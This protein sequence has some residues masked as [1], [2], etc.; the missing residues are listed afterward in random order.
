MVKRKKAIVLLEN[1][2]SLEGYSF[3]AE[4]EVCA[5][6]VFNTAM[7]GYQEIISD[8]SYTGQAVVMTYPLIGNYGVNSFDDESDGMKAEALIVKELSSVA[9]NWM[10]EGTLADYLKK[11]NRIG[12]EGV[13]TRALTRVLRTK[14][15]MKGI[16]STKD[17]D[18]KSLKK[19]LSSAP[20]IGDAD[21][22]SK[23]S[24]KKVYDWKDAEDDNP[25]H[26]SKHSVAVIDCGVKRSI[27]RNMKNYFGK[28][29]VFPASTS[30]DEV[31][32]YN[33]DGI[34]LSNGPGDPEAVTGVVA[35][36][37][38][39]IERL[40]KGETKVPLLGICLGHQMLGLALGGKTYKLTFG[41]H[42]GNHPVKDL[43][44]GRIDITS[45][46]HNY[47]VDMTSLS[48]DI[49]LTHVNLY[50]KTP[51]GMQHKKLPIFSVQYHPEAGPGP[52]DAK[53][54]FFE[55]KRII[56]ESKK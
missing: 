37:K 9:S 3:G 49:E 46:N 47:C 50:D 1:G 30:L 40:K 54:V 15:A 22:A 10:S 52:F 20:A 35:F 31:M 27:L 6:I 14:G 8:P 12:I 7:T 53:H 55:F 26:K 5:E 13:D 38:Q 48:K 34:L 19:K 32:K 21:L 33:P 41:H 24:T 29:T 25:T 43:R 44:S 23:V 45:Q 28:V 18:V 2:Y 4:G 36:A 17:F 16:I 56:D 11:H 42:G 39:H 51:E